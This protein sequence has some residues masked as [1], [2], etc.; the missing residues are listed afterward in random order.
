M[1]FRGGLVLIDRYYYDFLI[2]QR[3]YRLQVPQW[4]VRLGL[5]FL[6]KPDLVLLLDAPADVLQ[7]R[8]Q[9]VALTETRRQ[10]DVL[11]RDNQVAV[12]RTHRQRRSEAGKCSGR[13]KEMAPAI[14][15]GANRSTMKFWEELFAPD[16]SSQAAAVVEMRLLRKKGRP[17]LLLPAQPRLAV[18]CLDLYPAQ[19]KNARAAKGLLRQLVRFGWWLKMERSRF[20]L[21]RSNRLD[22]FFSG[23]RAYSEKIP[24]IWSSGR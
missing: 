24:R 16:S 21:R 4:L 22:D 17:L 5:A 18:Q 6:K 10:R 8:K 9:E 19:T 7:S 15:D 23:L 20:G 2:D 13:G 14:H 1:T 3:R 11:S 12:E